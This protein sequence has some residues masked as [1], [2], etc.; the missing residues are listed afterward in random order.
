MDRIPADVIRLVEQA[1]IVADQKA[2]KVSRTY[3]ETQELVNEM[4]LAFAHQ[5]STAPH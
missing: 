2:V 4:R 3:K 1:T 5:I